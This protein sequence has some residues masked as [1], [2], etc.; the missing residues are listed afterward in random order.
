M[1]IQGSIRSLREGCELD[2]TGIKGRIIGM[3]IEQESSVYRLL[4]RSGILSEAQ[5]QQLVA[6]DTSAD[7]GV[8]ESVVR[9]G[10]VKE[11]EFLSG[12]SELLGIPYISLSRETPPPEAIAA[13]PA[14]AV[15]LYQVVPVSFD[16]GHLMVAASEPFD[17]GLSDA[18]T[19]L[20]QCPVTLALSPLGDIKKAARKFYGVGA[21]TVAAMIEDGRFDVSDDA[22]STK[23]DL[24]DVGQEASIVRFVNQVI[25]EADNQDATDIHVEPM[26]DEL[27]IR[28]RIDG[29]LHKVDVPGQLNRLQAA[30]ISR[31]KVMANLDIAEK[32]MPMDGRIGIRV[33]GKDID[34]RVSTMPTVYGESI[35][36]RLLQK[37][38]NFVDL[39]DLGMG[40]RDDETIRRIIRRP[41]GIV[42]V[43]GPTGSGKSTSL[44]AYL[45]EI[46]TMDKRIL[47]AEEP[48]EYE[49]PGINQVLVRSDIGLTFGRILR[50]FLRQDPDVIMV[51]EIRDLETA[52]IAINA[53]LTGHLV[54]STLH[55]NDASGAFAR[56]I[57][58]G[59]EPFLVA[60][61]VAGVVAQRLVRR[62]CAQCKM[63]SDPDIALMAQAGQGGFSLGEGTLYAAEGCEACSQTGFRGRGGIFE[64]LEVTDAIESLVIGRRS[65]HEVKQKAVDEGMK[66]LRDDGWDKVRSGST[67]ISEVLR[68]TEENA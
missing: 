59:V 23:F 65:S 63:T 55:T 60:S 45:N 35:S 1:N 42:L 21:D 30:I 12:M 38:D 62:L 31:I 18:L 7:R 22:D 6:A 37:T 15:F 67:T 25:S 24:G 2:R 17:A 13:L 19:M 56:L 49:M 44:Y 68:V 14:R 51:G 10:L 52:E 33:Q 29:L 3:I 5:L 32:R 9:L 40:R 4:E 54:F 50:S 57:D 64:L 43:T 39:R 41:N 46:N 53:S 16:D 66:T 34:I 58:M 20:T 27:R 61:A 26:E 47:T 48:I 36:L 8:T 11:D 28:Y